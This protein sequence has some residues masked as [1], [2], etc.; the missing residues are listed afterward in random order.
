MVICFSVDQNNT[1]FKFQQI[2]IQIARNIR[3]FDVLKTK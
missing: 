3:I 1:I 2:L